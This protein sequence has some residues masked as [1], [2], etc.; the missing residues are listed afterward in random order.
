MMSSAP[1]Q[2]EDVPFEF[3]VQLGYALGV[4]LI[5]ALIWIRGDG[6]AGVSWLTLCGVGL[7]ICMAAAAVYSTRDLLV[8]KTLFTLIARLNISGSLMFSAGLSIFG[9]NYSLEL[10]PNWLKGALVLAPL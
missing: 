3:W 2:L 10:W 8:G 9:W 6:R 4:A 7:S 1:R 5:S